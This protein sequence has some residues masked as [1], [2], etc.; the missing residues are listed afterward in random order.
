MSFLELS[1]TLDG[2]DVDNAETACFDSGAISVT[3]SDER[4]R[5]GG[6]IHDALPGA[7]LEPALGE[8]R[9]WPQT[10]LQALFTAEIAGAGLVVTVARALGIEPQRLQLRALEDRVWE[11]EWLRDFHALRFG[12]RLWVCP[13]HEPA[14]ANAIVVRLDPG[15][16]FG[17]GTHPSTALCLEWLDAQA[18]AG[19]EVLDYGCGCGL[20]AIAALKLGA[21]RAHAYDIDPQALLA[22]RENA[23][24]NGVA[25]RLVVCER[26]TELPRSDVVMANILSETLRS[27]APGL[28]ALVTAPGHLLLS[29]ILESQQAE[30][31]AAYS[32]WF[33]MQQC[34]QHDGWV[35]LCGQRQRH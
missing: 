29:G 10:R 22:T 31:A 27:L 30:V 25:D 7:V 26:A 9:L 4:D 20:L 13:R 34:G 14:P 11:R 8:V 2:L 1:F 24:D 21:R 12:R 3:L 33:D 6:S 35:A 28:A 17:T 19:L 16:A 15:L 32:A 23:H 18:L 5:G